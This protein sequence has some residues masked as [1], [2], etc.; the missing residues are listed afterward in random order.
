MKVTIEELK[1]QGYNIKIRHNRISQADFKTCQNMRALTT[2]SFNVP[3]LTP[4]FEAMVD[5]DGN[6]YFASRV[7]YEKVDRSLSWDKIENLVNPEYKGIKEF[8]ENEEIAPRG[9]FTEVVIVDKD[10]VE[11]EGRA[12]CSLADNYCRKRGIA[13]AFSRAAANL[14]SASVEPVE[15]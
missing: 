13:I 12:D 5:D 9:G 10:G 3:V 1:K 7:A 4:D 11:Y 2:Q 6:L 15:G 8:K 14:V